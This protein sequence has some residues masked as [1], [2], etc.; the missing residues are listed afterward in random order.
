[1]SLARAWTRQLY[2]A[3][4]AALLVPGTIACALAV[5]AFA[6][7]FARLGSIGQALS[8]PAAPA[9]AQA[10][11]AAGDLR[12]AARLGVALA[13]VG[14]PA[15]SPGIGAAPAGAA[16]GGLAGPGVSTGS[17]TG[18]GGGGGNS[19]P[20]GGG[21]SGGGTGGGAGG[22]GGGGGGGSSGGGRPGA[23]GGIGPPRA[24][25][26]TIVDGVVSAGTSVTSQV[27]GPVGTLATQTLD[28]V[29]SAVDRILPL[30]PAGAKGATGTSTPV[31]GLQAH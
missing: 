23:G 27:P 8:G 9:A 24:P 21:T 10:G 4:G 3:W 18:N 5:L 20:G 30:R 22:G 11:S 31:L 7:G 14:A 16:T 12:T 2:G 13:A 17:P 25:G 29:G 6:G 28:S 26:P 19:G 1:M 15:S